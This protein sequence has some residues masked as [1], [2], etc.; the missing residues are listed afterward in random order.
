M[1]EAK[2]EQLLSYAHTNKETKYYLI[3]STLGTTGIRIQ[4]LSMFTVEALSKNN[5]NI[6]ILTGLFIS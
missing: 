1:T 2:Y 4:E 5:G 6:E 3:M